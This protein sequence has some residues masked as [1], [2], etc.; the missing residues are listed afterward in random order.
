MMEK[1]NK[2]EGREVYVLEGE[3]GLPQD[4]EKTDMAH[5][6]MAVY[7]GANGTPMLGCI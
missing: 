6:K 1:R 4:S 3:K 7:K 2:G 5:R